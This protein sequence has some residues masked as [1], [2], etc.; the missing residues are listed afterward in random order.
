MGIKAAISYDSVQTNSFRGRENS[1]AKARA[2]VDHPVRFAIANIVE[3]HT[4]KGTALH[5][6]RNVGSVKRTIILRLCANRAHLITREI[7]VNTDQETRV[8]KRNFMK[9]TKRK[10]SWMTYLTG[11]GIVLQ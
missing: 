7:A 10:E 3:N 1:G 4:I 2:M 11:T 6:V 9:L 8:P 5:L